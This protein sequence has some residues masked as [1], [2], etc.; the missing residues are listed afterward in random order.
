MKNK[1][2]LRKCIN[3]ECGHMI[4][5]SDN[6]CNYCGLSQRQIPFGRI[7]FGIGLVG[8]V[9]SLVLL[10]FPKGNTPNQISVQLTNTAYKQIQF[11][12]AQSSTRPVSIP[13]SS[14]GGEV[15]AIGQNSGLNIAPKDGMKIIPVPAGEFSMGSDGGFEDE[16]PVHSVYLNTFWIGQTEVTNSMYE[17]CVTSGVCSPQRQTSFNPSTG[18]YQFGRNYPNFPA[19]YVNWNQA[20]T[21]CSW[22]N[23]RLP[24]EAEW[25]KAARGTNN[26][27]YPWGN[28]TPNH[29]L[30]NYGNYLGD[31]T[32]VGSFPSGASPYGVLDMAGNVWEW[33]TDYYDKDYYSNSPSQNPTGPSSG[34]THILKGG[35]F[36]SNDNY[37]RSATRDK[38]GSV[39][40]ESYGSGNWGFRCVYFGF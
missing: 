9:A 24:T 15:S 22:A 34:Q 17:K 16:K 2:N 18:T 4:P 39:S 40:T 1:T 38:P 31:T 27:T 37:I 20:S 19:V 13:T 6:Y 36:F 3:P 8:L 26:I 12:Q 7:I 10:I 32:Q 29:N 33:V 21:Y 25:E 30:A 5:V 23:G 28:N 35:S 14:T 11:L